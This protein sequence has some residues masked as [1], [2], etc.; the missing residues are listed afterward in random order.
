MDTVL[1]TKSSRK[2]L[3]TMTFRRNNLMLLFLLS[4][5][6][7]S[8][9]FNIFRYLEH[10]LGLACFR[11]VFKIFLTDNGGEFKNNVNLEY[12]KDNEIRTKVY[13]CDPMA[14]W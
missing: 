7:A 3:L 6:K 11:R 12:T 9:V 5:G 10:E 13:H 1:G 2:R 8:S 14:S 4:D